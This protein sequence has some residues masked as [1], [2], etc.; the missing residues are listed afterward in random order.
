MATSSTKK[1]LQ[2]QNVIYKLAYL[3]I[4]AIIWLFVIPPN[5]IPCFFACLCRSVSDR[6]LSSPKVIDFAVFLDLRDLRDFAFLW[7]DCFAVIYWME[8]KF[9]KNLVFVFFQ[10]K[11]QINIHSLQII[12]EQIRHP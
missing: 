5:G 4:F 2:L 10:I 6:C 12:E 9:F 7:E 1:I 8:K 3:C 11:L